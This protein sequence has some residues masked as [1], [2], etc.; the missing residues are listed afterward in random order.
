[1]QKKNSVRDKRDNEKKHPKAGSPGLLL[2]SVFVLSLCGIIYELILGSLASYL[3]GNPVL[4]YSLTIGFFLS[5]M[6]LGSYLSRFF[7]KDLVRVFVVVEVLLGVTGGISVFIIYYFFSVSELFYYLHIFFLVLIGT[8]V[9]LEIPLVTRILKEYGDLKDILSNV[10]SLDYLGGL[11]GSLL[12]PLVMY[13]FLGRLTASLVI[14]IAN[15]VVALILVFYLLPAHRIKRIVWLPGLAIVG[16]LGM[17]FYG[18]VIERTLEQHLYEDDIVYSGQT[19]FQ[20]IVLT[21]NRN[22]FRLYLDG[23][24]QFSTSDEYR[25]HEMLVLPAVFCHS[26]N[27]Q[28]IAV[29]GGGDGLAMA[30]LLRFDFIQ[31]ID[32]VELDADMVNLA[33]NHAGF[34]MI[35][36]DA[37]RDS[38]V[39][40]HIMD[41]FQ[42][43]RNPGDL[44]DIIIADFPDPH[45][46][47]IARLY[48]REFYRILQKRLSPGGILVT[49]STSP[50]FAGEAFWNIHYTMKEVFPEV[51]P[52]HVFVPSFGQWGFNMAIPGKCSL[53]NKSAMVK[54]GNY[55]YFSIPIWERSRIFSKDEIH[56]R[57]YV[58]TFNRPTV[59]HDYLQGWKSMDY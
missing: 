38:R 3:A 27:P 17:I 29:L 23:S 30:S 42:F 6:G 19:Q 7:R 26:E 21:R 41:A 48:S 43:M 12:F 37:V 56:P 24:L 45:D 55:Q 9:G 8:L 51:I 52:Y 36:R 10:L 59:F 57:K 32:L 44:Y 46:E 20:R 16:M 18:D 14:G 25:Y 11:A 50:L 2:F 5:S 49:Q 54:N 34:R 47:V 22:D 33:R 13:P 31:S 4:Q 58:T 1:M 15:S 53:E 35:N 40:V 28:K 39:H